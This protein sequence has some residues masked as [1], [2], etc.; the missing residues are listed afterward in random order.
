MAFSVTTHP[1][2][3][4]PGLQSSHS[5]ML[6]YHAYQPTGGRGYIQVL[7][8]KRVQRNW[9]PPRASAVLEEMHYWLL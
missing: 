3:S 1:S 6:G 5:Q 4:C 2:L 7:D 8:R 9:G